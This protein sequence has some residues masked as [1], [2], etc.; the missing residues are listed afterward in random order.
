MGAASLR[1][2]GTGCPG[3]VVT[4]VYG[5]LPGIEAGNPSLILCKRSTPS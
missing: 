3:A 5:L 1:G 2:K 4:Q